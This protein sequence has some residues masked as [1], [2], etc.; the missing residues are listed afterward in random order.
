PARSPGPT[1]RRSPAR[2]GGSPRRP[3]VPPS[4]PALPAR[5][6]RGS[7]RS[8]TW[9]RRSRALRQGAAGE[10]PDQPRLDDDLPAV[11]VLEVEQGPARRDL[12]HLPDL[13]QVEDRVL[14]GERPRLDE[15]L[16]RLL[17]GH[18]LARRELA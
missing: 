9:R 10:S 18:F 6:G 16:H 11:R 4:P 2:R 17:P 7:P 12:G 15:A 14:P 8:P 5:R 1:A 3:A 13:A